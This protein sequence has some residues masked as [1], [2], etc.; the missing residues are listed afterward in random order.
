MHTDALQNQNTLIERTSS[1]SSIRVL[2]PKNQALCKYCVHG[3]VNFRP[4]FETIKYVILLIIYS[5]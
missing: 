3:K 2:M 5:G 1:I 4:M